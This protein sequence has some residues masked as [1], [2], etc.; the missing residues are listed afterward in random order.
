MGAVLSGNFT[1]HLPPTLL[2]QCERL[3]F[4]RLAVW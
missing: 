3:S 4:L 1:A 2:V